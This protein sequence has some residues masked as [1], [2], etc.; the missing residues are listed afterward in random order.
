MVMGERSSG[1]SL[2]GAVELA[3]YVVD[4]VAQTY[5]SFELYAMAGLLY[6]GLTLAVAAI[7]RMIETRL[8]TPS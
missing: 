7:F 2:S 1:A 6:L 5:R 3:E 8:R 4:I